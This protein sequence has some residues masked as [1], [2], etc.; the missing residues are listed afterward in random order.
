MLFRSDFGSLLSRVF[1]PHLRK[2]WE[3]TRTLQINEKWK[4][5]KGIERGRRIESVRFLLCWN[6]CIPIAINNIYIRFYVWWRWAWAARA[7]IIWLG[8]SSS[9]RSSLRCCWRRESNLTACFL[10]SN[11][12]ITFVNISAGTSQFTSWI[13]RSL[14][15]FHLAHSLSSW[16]LL[17]S[18]PISVRFLNRV[19][20]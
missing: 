3:K 9:L 11:L 10:C 5:P 6:S 2:R 16:H 19:C 18:I 7:I 17:L 20:V 1:D 13:S 14:I 15:G 4:N 8:E 12:R